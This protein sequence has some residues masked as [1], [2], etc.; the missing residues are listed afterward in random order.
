[1]NVTGK[2]IGS[3]K[4]ISASS[5]SPIVKVTQVITIRTAGKKNMT[6]VI[7]SHDHYSSNSPTMKIKTM[8]ELSPKNIFTAYIFCFPMLS[9]I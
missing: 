2:G 1:M 9:V 7:S 5:L 4:V 8:E 6:K 3:G